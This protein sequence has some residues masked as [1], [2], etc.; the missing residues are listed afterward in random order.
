M[1]HAGT[2]VRIP[3]YATPSYTLFLESVCTQYLVDRPP[4]SH[5]WEFTVQIRPSN[6]MEMIMHCSNEIGYMIIA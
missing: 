4:S 6:L 2:L 1:T 3:G 5:Q